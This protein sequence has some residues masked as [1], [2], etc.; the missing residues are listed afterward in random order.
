MRRWCLRALGLGLIAAWG[1]LGSLEGAAQSLPP[2]A[3]PALQQFDTAYS[4]HNIDLSTLMSGGP[5]KDGIPS[6]DNPSSVSVGRRAGG[7]R[8][9]SR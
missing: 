1:L 6:V 5:P 7:W 3:P 9:R 8:R 2:D 4:K